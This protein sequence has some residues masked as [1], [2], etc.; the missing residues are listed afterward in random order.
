MAKID[1]LL[2]DVKR[3]RDELAVQIHLGSKEARKE[4]EALEQKWQK[5]SAD[6]RLEDSAKEIGEAASELGDELK[7]AYERIKKALR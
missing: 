5:F 7:T 6:A 2:E 1:D 3:K 4:W